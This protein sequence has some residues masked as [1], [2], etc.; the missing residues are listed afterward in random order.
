MFIFLLLSFKSSLY[1]LV[2]SPL[3]DVSFVNIFSHSVTC[4]LISLSLS[5]DHSCLLPMMDIKMDKLRWKNIYKSYAKHDTE[6]L[7]LYNIPGY[8]CAL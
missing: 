6:V 8:C 2:N 1:I 3:L 4:L 7:P 5:F